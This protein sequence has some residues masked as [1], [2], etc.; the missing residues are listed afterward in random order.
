MTFMVKGLKIAYKSLGFS[1]IIIEQ[2][3]CCDKAAK[4]GDYMDIGGL[5]S[6]I[7]VIHRIDPIISSYIDQ[8]KT[9][10]RSK[11]KIL[12]DPRG[13]LKAFTLMI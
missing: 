8:Y 6:F 2:H 12:I 10:K 9:I 5:E 13:I 7:P 3:G 1:P 11:D 4:R